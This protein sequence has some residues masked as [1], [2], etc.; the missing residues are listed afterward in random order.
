MSMS[1]GIPLDAR[2]NLDTSVLAKELQDALDFDLKYK[3]T[4]NMKKRAIRKAGSYDEF[5]A[6]VACANLKT[7]SS[8]EVAT[9]RDVKKGWQKGYR[10]DATKANA[11]LLEG[12]ITQQQLNISVEGSKCN[13]KTFNKPRTSM[14][15]ERD[16]RHCYNPEDKIN[17][18]MLVGLKRI[19]M[20]MTNVGNVEILEQMLSALLW[21]MQQTNNTSDVPVSVFLAK[22]TVTE[23]TLDC[24]SPVSSAVE[25]SDG[26]EQ[27][28][29][30]INPFKWFKA[31]AAF[32]RFGLLRMSLEKAILQ[33]IIDYL[34][35]YKENNSNEDIEEIHTVLQLY[36]K[37]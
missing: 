20:I 35:Q 3:K 8:Q 22:N 25:A 36:I 15:F 26:I 16:W 29:K 19:K 10:K 1:S 31:I 21:H 18:L 27:Q 6:M 4:D 2:G 33:Q 30:S 28:E 7:I 14:E 17:Y 24:N 9:L 12:E 32:Q 11:C 5:K 34:L 37:K 23:T 13:I